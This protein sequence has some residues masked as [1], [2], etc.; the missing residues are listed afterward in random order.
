[1]RSVKVGR[2]EDKPARDAVD[3]YQGERR[4]ELIT[5]GNEHGQTA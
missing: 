3:L 2:T 1:M 5:G 4:G